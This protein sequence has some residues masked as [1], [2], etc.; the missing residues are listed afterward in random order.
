MPRE[1]INYPDLDALEPAWTIPAL[2]VGWHPGWLQVGLEVDTAYALFAVREPN[3][4]TEKRTVMWSP[5]LT[6]AEAEKMIKTLRK[7]VR[8]AKRK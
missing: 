6:V 1:Q 3:G 7:A 5:T 4:A 8:V 2:H